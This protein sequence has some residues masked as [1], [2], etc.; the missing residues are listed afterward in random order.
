MRVRVGFIG[1]DETAFV[2]ARGWGEPV[3]CADADRARALGLAAQV[4]GT[5]LASNRAVARRAEVVLLCHERADLGNIAQAVAPYTGIIVS[6]L[7]N[8]PLAVVRGAYPSCSVYRVAVNRPTAIARGVSVLADG[9]PQP[10]DDLVRSLFG[11]LGRVIV[12]DDALVDAAAAVMRDSAA[13]VET[14]ARGDRGRAALEGLTKFL[15]SI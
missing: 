4:G 14:H 8:T 13:I 2:L 1:C 6:T 5:A 11:R 10:G 12:L 7:E 9:P 15:G 3:L